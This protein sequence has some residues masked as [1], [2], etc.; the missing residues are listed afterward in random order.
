MCE[1]TVF[2]DKEI[3]FR[4]VVYAKVERG[5]LLLKDVLGVAKTVEN[6]KIIEVDVNSERLV[7]SSS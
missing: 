6:C 3:V 2:L 7:L 5:K 4:D 1:F